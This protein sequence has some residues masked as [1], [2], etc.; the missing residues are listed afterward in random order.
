MATAVALILGKLAP[1]DLQLHAPAIVAKLEDEDGNVRMAADVY[2]TV[3]EIIASKGALAPA[4][5]AAFMRKLER[6]RRYC[7]EAWS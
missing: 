2:R 4:A 3:T 7:A 1:G 5:A 6:E